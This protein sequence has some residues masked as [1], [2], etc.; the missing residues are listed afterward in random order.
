MARLRHFAKRPAK[1]KP[2]SLEIKNFGGGQG[3][4]S[5]Q[6]QVVRVC[7]C[8]RTQYRVPKNRYTTNGS[9][10]VYRNWPRGQSHGRRV[11]RRVRR[12][13]GFDGG[14]CRN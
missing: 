2:P 5:K 10:T 4:F 1:F 6:L 12:V 9:E 3:D 7:V 14:G 11:H 13:R 8:R